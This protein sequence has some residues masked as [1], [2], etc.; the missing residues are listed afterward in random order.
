MFTYGNKN[1]GKEPKAGELNQR[2]EIVCP[3]NETNENG[4][5]ES[6]DEV[7]CRVWAR[8]TQSGDSTNPEA[9][10]NAQAS[11]LNFAIRYRAGIKP[12]MA[13]LFDGGRYEIVAT[14]GYSFRKRFLGMKTVQAG[15]IG[16]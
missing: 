16:L 13:V 9:N 2:I 14:G 6:R 7:I 12:G 3:I 5:P 8:V 1:W 10:A 4:Y 11:A 15:V